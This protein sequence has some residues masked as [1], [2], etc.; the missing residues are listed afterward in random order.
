MQPWWSLKGPLTARR[1]DFQLKL[2]DREAGSLDSFHV[3]IHSISNI[4]CYNFINQWS[5]K[6]DYNVA[7]Q[8]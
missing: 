3:L 6:L 5:P 8:V 4:D 1:N 7:N 2:C